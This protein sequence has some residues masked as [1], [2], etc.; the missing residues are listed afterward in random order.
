MN[1]KSRRGYTLIELT[2][3]LGVSSVLAGMSVWL[4]QMSM[5]KTR[6]GQR[7]LA[8]RKAVARLAETFRRDVHAAVSIA[9]DPDTRDVP[10]WNLRL[11]SGNIVRYRLEPGRLVRDEPA[12]GHETF[13]LPPGAR[14]SINLELPSAPRIASLL[15]TAPGNKSVRIDA[16]MSL[17]HRFKQIKTVKNKSTDPPE[18]VEK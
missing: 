16:A 7:H 10:V 8:S 2:A 3:V 9:Q 4:V 1:R 15:I 5:Q 11:G 13:N 6:D 18:E 14:L 17:D 12:S